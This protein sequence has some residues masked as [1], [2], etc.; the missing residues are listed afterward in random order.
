M[1]Y[2]RGDHF[3]R[4]RF[5][6]DVWKAKDGRLL[7]RFWS[8]NQEIDWCSYKIIG[9]KVTKCP[10]SGDKFCETC[11]VPACLRDEYDN[12]ILSEN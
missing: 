4:L 1:V 8:R 6:L 3:G 10:H 5:Y 9:L 12:W 7:A 11:W 2:G